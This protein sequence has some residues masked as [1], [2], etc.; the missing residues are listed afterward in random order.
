MLRGGEGGRIRGGG[1]GVDVVV[2]AS[3]VIRA[4]YARR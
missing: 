1:V 3:G 4:R 2:R